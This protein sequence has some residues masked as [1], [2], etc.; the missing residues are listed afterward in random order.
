[1]ARRSAGLSVSAVALGSIVDAAVQL[2]GPPAW[3]PFSLAS[4]RTK[5][6]PSVGGA[7]VIVWD[8]SGG[9]ACHCPL[10]IT[11]QTEEFEARSEF[12]DTLAGSSRRACSKESF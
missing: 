4:M 2:D 10:K 5:T 12:S 7:G 9:S 1:M 8:G 6:H 3:S 11:N